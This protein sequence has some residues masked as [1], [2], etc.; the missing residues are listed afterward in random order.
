MFFNV[1]YYVF[2][3]VIR[4]DTHGLAVCTYSM[5][6]GTHGVTISRYVGIDFHTLYLVIDMYY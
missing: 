5:I 6:L 4:Y 2:S 3:R 1:F